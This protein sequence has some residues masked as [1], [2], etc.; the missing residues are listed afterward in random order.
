MHG[1]YIAEHQN[2]TSLQ[3]KCVICVSD[4]PEDLATIIA[5]WDNLPAVKAGIVA[6]VTVARQP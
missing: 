1:P 6:I 3:K 2:D 4:F 5:A